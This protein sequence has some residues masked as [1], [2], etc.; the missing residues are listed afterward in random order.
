MKPEKTADRDKLAGIIQSG[1]RVEC[2]ADSL[3]AG[4]GKTF[5]Y[6]VP[7]PAQTA[8]EILDSVPGRLRA[9]IDHELE[10]VWIG[11]GQ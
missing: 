11:G 1:Y 8:Y 6:W 10:Q 5:G 2:Y 3:S 4:E 7:V 9:S